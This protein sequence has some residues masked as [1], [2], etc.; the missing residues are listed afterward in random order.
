M[1]IDRYRRVMSLPV[2]EERAGEILASL[3]FEI[4]EKTAER[5]AVA[6][7]TWR[8]DVTREIDLIEEV[9]R[10]EGYDNVPDETRMKVS[11]AGTSPLDKAAAIAAAALVENGFYETVTLSFASRKSLAAMGPE[12]AEPAVPV[13]N[14]LS[15]EYSH[16]RSTLVPSLATVVATNR[17]RGSHAERFFEIARTFRSKGADEL[18]DEVETLGIVAEGD[19]AALKGAVEGVLAH[20]R[21]PEPRLDPADMTFAAPGACAR[22][23]SNGC[24]LGYVAVASAKTAAA[25]DLK[26]P[27]AAAELD[28]GAL[29]ELAR[30]DVT[31]KKPP[32]YPSVERDLAFVVSD[33]VLWRD[34]E[35]V[36]RESLPAEVTED[37]AFLSD[38]RGKGVPKGKK[39]LALRIVYR[40]AERTLSGDQVDGFQ[41][42]VIGAVAAALD[43]ELRGP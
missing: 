23:S 9:A 2:S 26:Q 19:F 21:V 36:V 17:D 31:Y 38:F 7:P 29:A 41:K 12:L 16:L 42:T 14:P 25:L 43:A 33:G 4:T 28:L 1:R 10:Y 5:I 3:G 15:T 39:S 37:V 11:V 35:R 40:S 30:H 6:V 13:A 34:I 20:L 24:E 32:R 22:V 8:D 18:P 27:F